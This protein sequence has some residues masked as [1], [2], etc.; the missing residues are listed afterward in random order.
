MGKSMIFYLPKY[1][2]IIET[3]GLQHYEESSMTSRSLQ[4]EIDND[5]F[6][7]EMALKNGIKKLYSN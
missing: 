6:K 3:H 1:N 5:L 7:Q 2:C 4:E